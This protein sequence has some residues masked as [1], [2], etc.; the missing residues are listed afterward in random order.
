MLIPLALAF[1]VQSGLL[2]VTPIFHGRL[3][4]EARM[5]WAPGSADPMLVIPY[6]L[7]ADG[8]W[9]KG[10]AVAVSLDFELRDPTGTH[11]LTR[12]AELRYDDRRQ[13]GYLAVPVTPRGGKWKLKA[14]FPRRDRDVTVE[15]TLLPL[16]TTAI[17]LS[18]IILGDPALGTIMAIGTDSI[19]L[20][21]FEAISA[22]KP[23]ELYFQVMNRGDE[24]ESRIDLRIRRMVHRDSVADE[25]LALAFPMTLPTGLTPIHRLVDLSR[26]AGSE[27]DI[28]VT[29]LDDS[30]GVLARR[31]T[32]AYLAQGKPVEVTPR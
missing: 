32:T 23:M 16:D 1:Q 2:D 22:A 19:T 4:A 24:R 31:S 8:G 18:D 30:A 11:R 25:V 15:G 10:A 28:V 5:L 17:A 7:T 13:I 27:Y 29:V 20:A 6:A 9:R 21:P 14:D 26:L 3:N 12:P